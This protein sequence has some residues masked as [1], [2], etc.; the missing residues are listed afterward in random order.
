GRAH[1][2]ARY[3]FSQ[4]GRTVVNRIDA[5]FRFREGRIVEHRDAFDLWR[6]TRQALG[7]KGV[8]LGWTS[9]VQRAIR[10]QARK[11]LDLYRRRQRSA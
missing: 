2:V 7:V 8:L 1:W 3:T 4:T 9:F 11:G 10:A 5:R 6:W